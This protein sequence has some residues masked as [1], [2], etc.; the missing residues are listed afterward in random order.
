MTSTPAAQ[1][2][3]GGWRRRR[4]LGLLGLGPAG[5]VALLGTVILALALITV[6]PRAALYA[7]PP[8]LGGAALSQARVGGQP[9]AAWVLIRI[10]W[11]RAVRRGWTSYRAGVV[12]EHPR[13]FQLPGVLAADHADLR[14]GRLRRPVRPGVGPAHRAPD[15][16]RPGDPGLPVA[17]RPGRRRP[18][19]RQL[20]RVAGLPRLPGRRLLGHRHGRHRARARD[21]PGRRRRR[22]H[23]PRRTR[24]GPADPRRRRRRLPGRRGRHR[25]PGF[26]HLRPQAPTRPGRRTW[27][28][29]PPR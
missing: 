4:P 13:A 25:G 3:Y 28:P 9:L 20:G 26:D 10:R 18:V 5:T 2:T 6:S 22:Q 8:L 15:R 14:P 12:V 21:H 16:H 19:G 7:D 27:P 17:G 23:Q 29:P 24:A 1:R 11:W